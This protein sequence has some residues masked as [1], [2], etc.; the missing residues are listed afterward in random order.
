MGETTISWTARPGTKPR[1]WNPTQGCALKSEGCRNCYAMRQ[2]RRFAGPGKPFDGL[3]NLKTGKWTG[4]ARLAAHKLDEPLSWRAPSTVFVDSMSD[5]FYEKFTNVEI[6]AVFGVMAATPQHTYQILTKRPDRMRAWFETPGIVELVD[7]FRQL[8][9]A[10]RIEEYFAPER[11]V[12]ITE[13]PGYAVTSKGRVISNRKG[14]DRDL[15]V[16]YSEQGHGRVQLY[17]TDGYDERV[18]V[19][20]LVLEAFDRAPRDGEQ[21]CHITG[22]A[23]NNALWNLRWGSQ[24]DNWQDRKRHGNRR[25]Y[26]KLTDE[27]VAELRQLADDGASG[28]ELG[29]LFGISDTQARNIMNGKQWAPE[30]KLEWPLPSV[31]LGVSVENQEAADERIPEL[32]ATPAAIRFLSCE[33]LLGPLELGRSLRRVLV[34]PD[35]RELVNTDAGVASEAGTWRRPIDWVIAGCESGPGARECRVDWLRSLRDQCATAPETSFFLKQAVAT[36]SEIAAGCVA[37]WVVGA[38]NGSS[39]KGRGFGGAVIEAPYLDGEQHMEWPL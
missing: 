23:T 28:A 4:E 1:T 30:Y 36:P 3:I 16:Q 32:L 14:P 5:L 8:A 2:A 39:Q 20:R 26:A 12:D 24:S 33:P 31:W 34:T 7:M 6:A 18:L 37:T 17:R 38:D 25:S 9:L 35:G 19:H 15:K 10:G 21:G 27:Q 13:W 29:R 11:I 22:D